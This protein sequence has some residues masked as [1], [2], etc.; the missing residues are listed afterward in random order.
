VSV[1]ELRGQG[2][3]M[4]GISSI[5][6]TKKTWN[7]TRGCSRVSKGCESCYAERDAGRWS[8]LGKPYEGLVRKT[9]HGWRWTGKMAVVEKDI[10]APLRWKEPSLVFVNSMSDLF[11]DNLDDEPIL[12]IFEV[13]RKAHWHVFQVLTKRVDRMLAFTQRLQFG[14]VMLNLAPIPVPNPAVLPNVW[15]GCSVEDQESADMRL[16]LLVQVPTVVRW[17]SCEPLLGYVDLLKW[18]HNL[19]WVVAGGESGP[20]A[21]P[22]HEDWAIMLRELCLF[23]KVPFFFKQWGQHGRAEDI[24]G[25]DFPTDRFSLVRAY[26][27]DHRPVLMYKAKAKKDTGRLLEGRTWDEFPPGLHIASPGLLRRR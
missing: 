25:L 4:A 15:L 16:P 7:P 27:E 21:R 10:E 13:M 23:G 18:I 9:S 26:G 17:L 20:G 11:H 14:S 6:W 3:L 12:R 8:G 2:N 1:S 22:M 5:E 24:K 19:H